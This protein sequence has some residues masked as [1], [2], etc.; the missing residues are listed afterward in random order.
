MIGR[1]EPGLHVSETKLEAQEKKIDDL[2]TPY[3]KF[4]AST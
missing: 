1:T 3:M 2:D 4:L